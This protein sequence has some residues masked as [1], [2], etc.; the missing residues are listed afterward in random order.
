MKVICIKKLTWIKFT[1]KA[2]VEEKIKSRLRLKAIGMIQ[3]G[4]WQYCY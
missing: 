3:V 2:K 1:K 4:T